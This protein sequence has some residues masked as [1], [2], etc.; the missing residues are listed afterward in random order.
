MFAKTLTAL[1]L[2]EAGSRGYTFKALGAG[3][4]ALR[5]QNYKKAIT[6]LVM[7]VIVTTAHMFIL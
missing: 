3:F 7:E 4:W 1:K 6:E 2:D 5:Q